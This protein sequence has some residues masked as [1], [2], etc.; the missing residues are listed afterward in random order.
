MCSP[1]KLLYSQLSPDK[2]VH[3]LLHLDEVAGEGRTVANPGNNNNHNKKKENV[4]W[5]FIRSHE[6]HESWAHVSELPSVTTVFSDDNLPWIRLDVE[7]LY[8]YSMRLTKLKRWWKWGIWGENRKGHYRSPGCGRRYGCPW[9]RRRRCWGTKA[10]SW[11]GLGSQT[12]TDRQIRAVSKVGLS[13]HMSAW[14]SEMPHTINIAGLTTS[15]LHHLVI[16]FAGWV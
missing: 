3:T 1:V 16:F 2:A 11:C 4:Y 10:Q 14:G 9:P 13:W 5:W 6:N 12:A 15:L 7:L 8:I